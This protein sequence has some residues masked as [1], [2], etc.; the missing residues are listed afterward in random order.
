MP[1]IRA[2]QLAPELGD[3]AAELA[4]RTRVMAFMLWPKRGDGAKREAAEQQIPLA[5]AAHLLGKRS[6][7]APAALSCEEGPRRP[8][9]QHAL[10]RA[11]EEPWFPELMFSEGHH[12]AGYVT[13]SL[14]AYFVIALQPH[15]EKMLGRDAAVGV[16][17]A[18]VNE[19]GGLVR[20][21]KETLIHKNVKAA[22]AD[23][24]RNKRA[25]HFW[26]AYLVMK[27]D[28]PDREPVFEDFRTFVGISRHFQ[29][30]LG[31]ALIRPIELLR[32]PEKYRVS[33]IERQIALDQE[34]IDLLP[35]Y[36]GDG[37]LGPRFERPH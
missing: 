17:C 7:V 29:K 8:G 37:D 22:M 30:I 13:A 35:F 1:T 2:P 4:M 16:A 25:A 36:K 34:L 31:G 6:P 24:G 10:I 26:A 15:T 20:A 23:W 28:A 27:L 14:V 21:N 32:L 18:I 3:K 5:V 19:F 9:Y 33:R 12:I 11:L